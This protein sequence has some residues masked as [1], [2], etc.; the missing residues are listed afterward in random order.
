V[1]WLNSQKNI[2]HL[3]QKIKYTEFDESFPEFNQSS[4]LRM[5][6]LRQGCTKHFKLTFL[7][8]CQNL[9]SRLMRRTQ[10]VFVIGVIWGKYVEILLRCSYQKGWYGFC[11]ETRN[12]AVFWSQNSEGKTP[13]GKSRRGLEDT[14]QMHP[15]EIPREGV[16]KLAQD[17]VI[18][19]QLS[20]NYPL[21]NMDSALWLTNAVGLPLFQIPCSSSRL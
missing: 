12:A 13:F 19:Y 20:E 21:I 11:G 18:H 16:R 1:R 5:K 7:C 14:V 3:F 2:C 8:E 10:I 17:K 4:Y 9:L 15:N 6:R